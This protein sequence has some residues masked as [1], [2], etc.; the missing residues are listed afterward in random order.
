VASLDVYIPIDD[1]Q[2]PARGQSLPD[3]TTGA[4]LFADV[5]SFTPLPEALIQILGP[6]HGAE[7][8]TRQLSCVNDALTAEVRRYRGSVIG[9]SGSNSRYEVCSNDFSRLHCITSD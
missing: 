6:K 1:R 8:E 4:A 3:R 2:A 7:E 9:S 5:S